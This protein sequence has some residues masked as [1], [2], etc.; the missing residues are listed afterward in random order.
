MVLMCS[1]SQPALLKGQ[2]LMEM[3]SLTNREKGWHLIKYCFF[4]LVGDGCQVGNLTGTFLFAWSGPRYVTSRAEV[5]P[6]SPLHHSKLHSRFG[7]CML[8]FSSS[9]SAFQPSLQ[10]GWIGRCWEDLHRKSPLVWMEELVI[11]TAELALPFHFSRK[12]ECF[13][14]EKLCFSAFFSAVLVVT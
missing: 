5:Q 2:F 10:S 9:Y 12:T 3:F 14:D 8:Q 4:T 13:K 11:V 6:F 7:V 1:G